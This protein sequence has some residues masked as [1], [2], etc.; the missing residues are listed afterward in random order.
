M[1]ICNKYF[2]IVIYKDTVNIH[3]GVQILTVSKKKN[4]ER[5]KHSALESP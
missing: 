1:N 4:D 5:N 2:K 3:S